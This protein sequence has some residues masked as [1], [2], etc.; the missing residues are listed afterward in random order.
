MA[1]GRRS[2]LGWP[3]ILVAI[4]GG[5]FANT[6]TQAPERPPPPRVSAPAAPTEP[7][8]R[9]VMVTPKAQPETAAPPPTT[10]P[11][12][13]ERL[14]ARQRVN[15][16]RFPSTSSPIVVRLDAGDGVVA[17]IDQAGW[18]EVATDAGLKG[19]I[20]ADLLTRS[21]PVI[22]APIPE[23]AA[24]VQPAPRAPVANIRP[25]KP[26]KARATGN[27]P[28]RDPYIGTCDCP[29]DFKRNGAICGG[30]SAFSRPG[31]RSPRCYE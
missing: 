29:Y 16:R 22:V 7:L 14:F 26:K 18:R 25:S 13:A 15:V 1:R 4:V 12:T 6:L 19:W 2:G 31:G 21:M 17:G 23:P 28:V 3:A 24:V 27:T 30:S 10:V 8:A 20:R 11:V 5:W 9:S